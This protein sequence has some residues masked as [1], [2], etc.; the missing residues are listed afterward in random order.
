[1]HH[2]QTPP[3]T[4]RQSPAAGSRARTWA[5]WLAIGTLVVA[6]LLGGFFII[7]GDQAA[8]AG[9]A[10]L[11]LVLVA[12]FAG[13]VTLDAGQSDGPNRWYLPASVMVNVVIVLIGLFKIWNGWLQPPNSADSLVWTQQLG[14]TLAVIV[15]LRLAL[16]ITQFYG[17][18]F[19]T[20]GRS[21]VARVSAG[22]T[23]GFIWLSA[24]F[25]AIP[26]AFPVPQWP[27]WWWR[28]SGAMALVALV[29]AV[30]PLIVRAFEP[31]QP[32]EPQDAP[33][34]PYGSTPPPSYGNMPQL[35]SAPESQPLFP[36]QAPPV[37]PPAPPVPPA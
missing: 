2:D 36:R 23:L 5:L 22:V 19:V 15:L 27:D 16:L 9:R 12:A 10:W 32:R 17:L 26:A 4:P 13:A 18:H 28:T 29:L 1:M 7:V 8:V 6:A 11:T 31:R 21:G 35:P 14:R 3:A 25:L 34:I 33:A 37:T 30:I 20:N 24:L